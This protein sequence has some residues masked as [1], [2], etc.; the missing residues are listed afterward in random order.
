MNVLATESNRACA[1]CRQRDERE[2]LLRFVA[3]GN[4]PQLAPDIRRRAP[5]RGVSVHPR[6]RCVDAAVRSGALRRAFGS[7]LRA[8]LSARE[9]ATSAANQYD[10][11]AAGLL[12]A[13]YRAR[14]LVIGTEA[15]RSALNASEVQ[16]LLIAE[17]AEGS[18]EDLVKAAERLFPDG[19]RCLVWSNKEELG[20][21]FGRAMLSI[22]GVL[23][24]GIATELRHVLRC[25]AEL[26]EDA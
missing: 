21:L 20:R 4:P 12:Q 24:T 17:D 11:R 15:T 5:G 16:L 13:A 8:D 19:A 7:E 22:A 6:Y 26:A 1:G 9:L 23:D 2:A 3:D 14:K 25:A 18:R 10:R